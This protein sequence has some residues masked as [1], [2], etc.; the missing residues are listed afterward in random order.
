MFA[1]LCF[2][3]QSICPCDNT[4]DHRGEI[5]RG[6]CKANVI[7]EMSLDECLND[8]ELWQWSVIKRFLSFL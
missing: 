8:R 7:I 2:L 4:K 1:D 5:A 3:I 6:H